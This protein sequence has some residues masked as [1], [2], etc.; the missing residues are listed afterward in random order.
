MQLTSLKASIQSFNTNGH[1]ILRL[2]DS[3]QAGQS[4]VIHDARSREEKALGTR[5]AM[6]VKRNRRRSNAS[7]D[8]DPGTTR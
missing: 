1:Y 7:A 6:Q 2:A 3:L 8:M 4:R 5:D